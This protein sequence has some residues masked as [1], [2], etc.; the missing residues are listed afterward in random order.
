[1]FIEDI[2]NWYSTATH[3]AKCDVVSRQN[4]QLKLKYL[5]K[6]LLCKIT[7]KK[8]CITVL[9]TLSQHAIKILMSWAL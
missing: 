5:N 2:D 9:N 6:M 8:P 3:Y 4:K 1:M 7:D